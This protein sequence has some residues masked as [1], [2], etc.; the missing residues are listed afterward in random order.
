LVRFYYNMLLVWN[1]CK[2]RLAKKAIVSRG[3]YMGRVLVTGASGFIGSHLVE[4]LLSEGDEVC[5]LLRDAGRRGWLTSKSIEVLSGDVSDLTALERA[6]QGTDVVYHAA[7]R[8]LSFSERGFN[9]V[10]QIGT[11]NLAAACA[12]RASPPVLVAISSLA[13]A[14]PSQ[15]ARPRVEADSPAPVTAYGRSKL[16]GEE[17]LRVHARNVP[18]TIIRPPG[19]FGPR[20]RHVLQMFQMV[21]R[22]WYAIV[23]EPA[24]EISLVEVRDLAASLRLAANHGQRLPAMMDEKSTG[25]YFVAQPEHP[26]FDELA[27][28]IARAYDRAPPRAIRVPFLA[29]CLLTSVAEVVARVRRRP[30]YLCFDRLREVRAGCWTCSAERARRELGAKS[31]HDLAEGI[32]QTALWYREQGWVGSTRS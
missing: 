31:R 22:G 23:G 20:E 6:V 26:T 25:I 9:Q 16:R 7:G 3:A 15:P 11:A 18:I 32:R 10:N 13:A 1:A 4:H 27:A 24:M 14:G 28:L 2:R 5:V 17:A 19:V 29:A 8:T 30:G 12:R 21:S